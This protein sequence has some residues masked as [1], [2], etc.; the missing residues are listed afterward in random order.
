MPRPPAFKSSAVRDLAHELRYAPATTRRRILT[1]A[2]QLAGEIE[3]DRVYPEEFIVY[4]VTGYRPERPAPPVTLV[5]AALVTDLVTL[6]QRLSR[7]L[8]LP[9]QSASPPARHAGRPRN[10]AQDA[11]DGRLVQ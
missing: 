11:R 3:R 5:G 4:R 9:A 1:A 10:M 8:D 7:R 6:I 2:E